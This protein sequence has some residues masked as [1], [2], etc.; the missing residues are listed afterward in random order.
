[1]SLLLEGSSFGLLVLLWNVQIVYIEGFVKG[2]EVV[3]LNSG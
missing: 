2:G 1:V 3:Q